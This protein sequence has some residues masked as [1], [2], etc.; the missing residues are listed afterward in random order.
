MGHHHSLQQ[1][2]D[3][4]DNRAELN[5][6]VVYWVFSITFLEDGADYSSPPV[7]ENDAGS[8]RQ[9]KKAHEGVRDETD[10]FFEDM[11]VYAIR[12]SLNVFSD[13]LNWRH[14][15]SV[16]DKQWWFTAIISSEDS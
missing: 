8:Q 6:P 16:A 10:E 5:R 13:K 2:H 14:R 12:D 3:F 1:I 15:W 11:Q 7:I 4:A 9:V